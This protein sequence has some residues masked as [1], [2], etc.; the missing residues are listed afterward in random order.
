MLVIHRFWGISTTMH[1]LEGK[2]CGGIKLEN[3]KK[4]P[5]YEGK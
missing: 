2:L 4:F 1:F 5:M 3:F